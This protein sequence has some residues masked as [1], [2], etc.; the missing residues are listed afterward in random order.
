VI[1][2]NYIP[3]DQALY[4]WVGRYNA[5]D[6]FTYL[7]FEDVEELIFEVLPYAVTREEDKRE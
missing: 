6:V 5:Q 3:Y 1:R 4:K 7:K 2:K